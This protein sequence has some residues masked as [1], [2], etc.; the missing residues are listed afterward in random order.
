[1]DEIYWHAFRVCAIWDAQTFQLMHYCG[2]NTEPFCSDVCGDHRRPQTLAEICINMGICCVYRAVAVR[3][4]YPG[5]ML[6]LS[7]ACSTLLFNNFHSMTDHLISPVLN[8][9]HCQVVCQNLHQSSYMTTQTP[10]PSLYWWH[11]IYPTK[12]HQWFGVS[13]GKYIGLL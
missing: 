11:L 13:A 12:E 5:F 1:M 7:P 8:G 2:F 6:L 9:F 4:K 3:E 10:L